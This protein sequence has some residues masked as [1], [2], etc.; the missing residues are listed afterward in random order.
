MKKHIIGLI[1]LVLLTLAIMSPV[2]AA[3]TVTITGYTVNPS[4]MMPDSLGTVTITVKNTASSASVS[5]K[6]GQLAD[7]T[8]ETVK[9]TD[10]NVNI[11]NVHLEGNGITVVTNDFKRVG[12]I[13]PG[14]S[15][16][17]T[18]SIQTP[19]KSGMYY[20]E[21]W[22]DTSG[23]RS[24]RYPILVNVNTA[25]G[26]QKQAILVLESNLTG[27]V[28]P[29]EELPVTLTLTNAGQTL[30]DDVVIKIE[31]VSTTVAPKTSDIY[32]IG[33]ISP[34]EVKIVDLVLLSDKK[35]NPG[36]VRIP[37]TL[38]YNAIDG[39][40]RT[41]SSGI[42]VMLKGSAELGFVSV[43][44]NPSRLTEGTPFD[45]T[46]RI[47]NTGTGEAKQVSAK[48]DLPA[49][50][51]REAFIGKI[52]PGN[53]APAIFLLEGMDGGTYPYNLTISYTDDMGFHTLTRT[54][55]LRVPPTDKT[56]TL[57][58]G[59]IIIGILGFLAYR[60]WYLP[61]VNG[62]GTFPWVKKN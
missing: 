24:T 9:T 44:T 7:S 51:T 49:E 53:D 36:L 37:V 26:I 4:V 21:V 60:Y 27:S 45:L 59:L 3:P 13:G 34:G 61:K 46:V 55:N 32:H 20:P 56:G 6:S 40:L 29:G 52:K 2:T 19:S 58:L 10:I 28:N 1:A 5:E 18:F 8:F 48:V 17:I 38:S 14:Q 15:I 57:I 23:G 16:P 35:A 39:A 62:D 54:M 31:N 25:T 43:D 47:E 33:I 12:E 30:A 11:E 22:I 41:Q 42:D 50:G